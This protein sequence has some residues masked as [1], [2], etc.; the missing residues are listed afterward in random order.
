MESRIVKSKLLL[1]TAALLASVGL[2]SPQGMREGAAPGGAISGGG[3]HGISSGA[4][5]GRSSGAE[6]SRSSPGTQHEQGMPSQTRGEGRGEGLREGGRAEGQSEPRIDRAQSER[7]QTQ[8]DQ[9][10]GQ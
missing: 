2:A 6:M 5:G 7:G 10:V 8:K 4:S 9:T 3:E 1:S